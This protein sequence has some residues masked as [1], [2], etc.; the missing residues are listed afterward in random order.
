VERRAWILFALLSSFWGASYMFIKIGLEDGLSA[1]AIVFWR[2]ALAAAV[3][4]PAAAR[5]GALA[6]LRSRLAPV[7]VLAAV[8]VAAPFLLITFGERHIPSSLAGI[9]VATAPIFTF[10]LAFAIDQEERASGVRLIGVAVGIAGV[11]LLLGVDT[12]GTT[13]ALVGGVM[14]ILASLGYALGSYYIKRRFRAVQPVGLVAATMAASAL[15][16]APLAALDLPA[17]APGA[18]SIAAVSAL[19][20]VGT[21]IAFVMFYELIGT[22]GPARASLVAYIAPGFAVLYGVALLGESFT[23]ATALGLVLIVVGSSVAAQGRLPR[24]GLAPRREL[25]ARGVDVPT[26]R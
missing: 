24:F 17:H 21:G 8:Q 6:D 19:G 20:V 10:L 7:V 13:A 3:L 22:M 18:G 11:G 12:S 16:T 9:L 1:P 5:M 23:V 14:I 4:L 15:M 26:A 25:A 2:T